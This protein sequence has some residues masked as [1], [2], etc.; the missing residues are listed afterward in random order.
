MIY[1]NK[2]VNRKLVLLLFLCFISSLAFSQGSNKKTSPFA[3]NGF[4]EVGGAGG[5][6]SLNYDRRFSNANNGFGGRIGIGIGEGQPT[7]MF[8]DLVLTIP[9]AVN[10]LAG[11]G[12]HYFEIGAGVTIGT[13]EFGIIN[14]KRQSLLF[15]PSLGYRYQKPIK[16]FMLR[17]VASPLIASGVDFWA[18]VSFGRRF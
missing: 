8:P 18:G 1:L 6:L 4:L 17:V 10:Y 16:G 5:F 15:V 2:P 3:S 12:P 9:I 11:Q 13:S 7:H 14:G